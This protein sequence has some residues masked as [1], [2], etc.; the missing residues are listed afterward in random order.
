MRLDG[1]TAGAVVMGRADGGGGQGISD[2][3][4]CPRNSKGLVISYPVPVIAVG[5]P[6]RLPALISVFLTHSSSVCGTQPIFPSIDSMV[7]HREACSCSLSSTSRIARSRTSGEN[8][9]VVL[10]MMAPPPQELSPPA[11]P[12]RFKSIQ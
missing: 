10:L 9:F 3:V 12:G 6:A 4:S 5:T 7:A 11:N 8:L 2:F 1:V